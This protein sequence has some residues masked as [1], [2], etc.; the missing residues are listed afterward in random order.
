[1]SAYR[2]FYVHP[3]IVAHQ[4]EVIMGAVSDATKRILGIS[5]VRSLLLLDDPH[6]T[7]PEYLVRVPEA[8]PSAIGK[9]RE[10][11]DSVLERSEIRTRAIRVL[12]ALDEVDDALLISQSKPIISASVR[13]AL[14][15][16]ACDID[17]KI[18]EQFWLNGADAGRSVPVMRSAAIAATT[19]YLKELLPTELFIEYYL[20]HPQWEVQKHIAITMFSKRPI[21]GAEFDAALPYLCTNERPEIYG[22]IRDWIN[23]FDAHRPP[24]DDDMQMLHKLLGYYETQD[25]A[26]ARSITSKIR[27]LLPD[28]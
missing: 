1:V 20:K 16:A 21:Y 9:L 10:L 11:A 22:R 4:R 24:G 12:I 19:H 15:D 6:Q 3:T 2:I 26:G 28:R 23:K 18:G 25:S 14:F 17:R 27:A 5:R 13:E 7:I 8:R